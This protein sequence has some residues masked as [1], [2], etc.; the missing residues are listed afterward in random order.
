M[1]LLANCYTA[2]HID[3]RV[4]SIGAAVCRNQQTESSSGQVAN[5]SG[6][7]CSGTR[8]L[9]LLDMQGLDKSSVPETPEAGVVMGCE[10]GVMQGCEVGV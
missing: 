3:S 10:A 4:R 5:F 9:I 1:Y 6:E 2:S 8:E 7:D